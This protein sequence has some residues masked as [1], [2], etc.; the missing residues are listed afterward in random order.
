MG[1]MKTLT[2]NGVTYEV[3]PVVPASSVTLLASAW[4]GEAGAYSQ[5]VSVPGVTANTKVD[6]QPTPEQLEEFHYKILAFVAENNNG[7]ITVYSI[8]DKPT[9]DC[10]IQITKTEVEGTGTIRGNTV[11]TT[12]PLPD[13]NQ[14]DPT[15]ADYI[16]NK[17]N[18]TPESIGAAPVGK[19]VNA[20]S[21]TTSGFYIGTGSN[22]PYGGAGQA[23]V[24]GYDNYVYSQLFVDGDLMALRQSQDGFYEAWNYINPNMQLGTEYRT[25]ERWQG[26]PVYVKLIDF[27]TL[28]AS[29]TKYVG[30]GVT[31]NKVIYIEPVTWSNSGSFTPAYGLRDSDGISM[32]DWWIN[33]S[34]NL[35]VGVYCDLSTYTAKVLIKYVKS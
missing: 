7:V 6:L 21:A 13:W 35:F 17:P 2:I 31:G 12:M 8:G 9:S 32:M 26:K 23:L 3:A 30:V 25:I 19:A 22:T 1:I 10:T 29:G 20:D 28:P 14:T 33:S 5:V 24:L 4:K 15:K 11:G 27:G 18:I 34:G 16:K